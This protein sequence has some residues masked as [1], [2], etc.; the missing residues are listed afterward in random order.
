M[1]Q[2]VY[3]AAPLGEVFLMKSVGHLINGAVR[4]SGDR[5]LD[6]TNPSTGKIDGKVSLASAEVTTER[7][8]RHK[9]SFQS[10]GQRHQLA[11]RKLCLDS[12]PCWSP[13]QMNWQH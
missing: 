2:V 9:R 10:G 8:L 11:E 13:I 3:T 4:H 5:H 7:S 6:I 12:R 1:R